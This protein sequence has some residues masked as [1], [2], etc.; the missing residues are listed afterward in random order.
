MDVRFGGAR[1]VCMELDTPNGP[2]QMSSAGESLE[3]AAPER[4]VYTESMSD[5]HG[6]PTSAEP[7]TEVHVDLAVI[8]PDRTRMV[9]THLGIPPGPPARPAG[10]WRLIAALEQARTELDGADV[11]LVGCGGAGSAIAAALATLPIASLTVHNRTRSTALELAA[12]L[13]SRHPDVRISD[14]SPSA[15]DF[16]LVINATRLGMTAN[17]PRPID[18]TG[19]SRCTVV[20]VVTG[21]HR[22][23]LL[24]DA[25]RLGLPT[26]DG[27]AM[28]R[29]QMAAIIDYWTSG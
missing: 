3:I 18:L 6:N 1:H 12:R 10:P 26:I 13:R 17:D 11:L 29:G 4:L 9:M 20:D 22:S 7:P 16:D 24:Q 8:D 19:A 5:E 21:P 25:D 23:N 28:L 15:A 27:T 14:G 2:M